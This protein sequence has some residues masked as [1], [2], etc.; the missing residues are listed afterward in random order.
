MTVTQ[1]IAM[2]DELK[3]NAFSQSVKLGW[4]NDCEGLVQTEVL[5]MEPEL[6]VRYGAQDGDTALIAPPPHDKLYRAYLCAMTDFA[7]GEYSKYQN[8]MQLFNTWFGE[9]QR[10]YARRFRP[11][12][13]G[14]GAPFFA[15]VRGTTP[16]LEFTDLPVAGEEATACSV[17]VTQGGETVLEYGLEDVVYEGGAITCP[18]SREDSLKLKAGLGEIRVAVTAGA[19][20]FAALPTTR[21]MVYE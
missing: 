17:T 21:V 11:A 13:G 19:E 5:L 1:A 18:I 12:D 20:H 16:V 3:P 15:M 2:A 7:N 6:C 9:Y 4:L 8:T 10:W 14:V